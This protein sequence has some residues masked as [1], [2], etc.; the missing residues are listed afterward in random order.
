LEIFV[1]KKIVPFVDSPKKWSRFED[2]KAERFGIGANSPTWKITNFHSQ[3]LH[4]KTRL[5]LYRSSVFFLEIFYLYD[6]T[7]KFQE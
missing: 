3:Q 2:V 5:Y 4:G 1:L 7:S 6:P